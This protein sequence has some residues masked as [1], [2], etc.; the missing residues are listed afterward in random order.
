VPVPAARLAP[1]AEG[2]RLPTT[3]RVRRR[4]STEVMQI[5]RFR[6]AAPHLAEHLPACRSRA[7]PIRHPASLERSGAGGEVGPVNIQ[8]HQYQYQYQL[9]TIMGAG[10]Y[11]ELLEVPWQMPARPIRTLVLSLWTC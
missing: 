8:Y 7:R 3:R 6:F 11:T 1:P 5:G 10:L 9:T 2:G 4:P